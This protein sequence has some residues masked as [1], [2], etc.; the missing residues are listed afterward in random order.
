M[1]ETQDTTAGA[2][3]QLARVSIE[4]PVLTWLIVLACLFGGW[5]GFETVGRLED[6]SFTIKESIV[7]T[8][9]PGASAE[10][11]EAE[12]SERLETAIQQMSQLEEVRSESSPGMSEIHVL[13]RDEYD[14]AELPQIWDELRKRVNDAQGTL[15]PGAGPSQVFDDFGDVY[16][17]LYAV[18]TPGYSDAEVRD[19]A[20]Y[21]RR[22][23]LTVE[24]VS[25][26]EIAGVPEERIYIELPQ[27]NL[28]RLGLPARRVLE[29]LS[30]ENAVVEAGET[31][32]GGRLLSIELPQTIGGVVSIENLLINPGDAGGTL[33]L[34]DIAEVRRAPVERADRYIYHNG[35]RAFTIGVSGLADANIVD[36]GAG[37]EG[38]L[39]DLMV[40]L[41][42]GVELQPIYEQHIVVDESINGFL[43]NL[44]MSLAIVIGVLCVFMGWRA[45]VTVGAVL[46]LTVLGTLAFMSGFDITMQ[47]ISLGALI[48]AMGML[49]DNAIVVT[50]GMQVAVQRGVSR[51]KAAQ[52]AVATTQWPLLGATV[53]GIMAFSGI[54]LSPDSTGE[55]LFS[56]FAVIGISLLLSWLLAITVAPMIAYHL[57]KGEKGKADADPYAGPVYGA[58]RAMLTGALKRR[59]LTVAVLLLITIASYVGFGQVRQSFFPD[60]NTPMFYVNIMEPQGTD[61]LTT[62]ETLRDIAAYAG[63]QTEAVSVDAFVGRG[64]TRFMLTYVSEQPNTAYGQL[65]VRTEGLEEI[66]ALGDR[67][68][69]YIA[70]NYPDVEARVDRIVFGPP[71]GAQLEAR[72][73]GPDAN[74]L[75][76]LGEEAIGRLRAEGDVRDLRTD[77][78]NRELVLRPQIV[79]ERARTI[80]LTRADIGDALSYA[81]EGVNVGVYRE[82]DTLI[83]II[84]RAPE[85]ERTI[86]DNLSDRLIWSPAQNTY[87]PFSQVVDG[88]ALEARDTLIQ[89]RDRVRTLTVQAN[90][91]QG[92]T[93]AS[94]FVRFSAIAESVELPR[95]YRLEWGG[96]HYASQQANESLGGVLPFSLLVMVVTSILLFQTVRQPLIIWL[97]VPM[98]VIGV[99]VGLLTTQ[100]AFSF[101]ALLGLLSL[102]GM[103]IKNAI[104]LVDELDQ[105]IAGGT[106]KLTAVLEGSVSRMRPVLLAAGTTI[107]GMTPLIFD[108]FFQGMAVTIISGLAFATVLTLIA[109]PVFYGLFFRVKA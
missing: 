77:W 90:P 30:N 6:P 55:F 9:Y 104:V 106:E 41:P 54:G 23:F 68:L 73:I 96:E 64:A 24:G 31:P 8:P 66:P 62:D 25:K 65:L 100:V 69:A 3:G 59:W 58:Y 52:D 7:F 50:E 101:T 43:I 105:R 102:S 109:T 56:L 75:R 87:V 39:A 84:A 17:I 103:L 78:R 12:V 97:V 93:A 83:P 10:E 107:L 92:E 14:G 60:S 44:I 38:K 15:P 63:A 40:N 45:G 26:V 27:E 20:D 51:M 72:F 80:G 32:A 67:I 13:I 81:T 4:K 57:F 42:I 98:S 88:F 21:L 35:E 86:A 89:R 18:A 53:I 61:I 95:G 94:A 85:A 74:V 79:E 108:A 33:R 34:S 76:A 48:I 22:E 82:G 49:V 70:D 71:S 28:A 11:V 91:P 99:T 2:R 47:R 5:W 46:L 16:G 1:S 19:I 36:V 29:A 37:V